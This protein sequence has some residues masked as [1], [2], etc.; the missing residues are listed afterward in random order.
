MEEKK[1][2]GKKKKKKTMS[3]KPRLKPSG[4]RRYQPSSLTVVEKPSK[5]R[6]EVLLRDKDVI[7]DFGKSSRGEVL[8]TEARLQWEGSE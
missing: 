3:Y 1:E 7:D 4:V 6:K 8:E 2:I 5:M